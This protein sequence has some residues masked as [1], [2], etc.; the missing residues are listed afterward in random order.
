M[1]SQNISLPS[2]NQRIRNVIDS[3][4]KGSVRAFCLALGFADSQKI[5]RLF[6]LDKRNNRYPKPSIDVL[7]LISNKLDISLLWLQTGEGQMLKDGSAEK[8]Q[9]QNQKADFRLVP[10]YNLDARG[11]F[12]DNDEVDVP[13]Y[14]VDHIPFKDAEENDICMPISGNSMAPTYCAGAIVLLHRVER[15]AEFLELGQVYMIVLKDGRRLIKELRAS[16]EDRKTK[17][18]CV[19]HNPAY[20]PVE[21]PKDMISL[22]FLVRAVYAKTAM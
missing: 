3:D 5:N 4:Y 16:Q 14:V 21:L 20:D 18:L 12:A 19:S 8:Q 22:V 13:E 10:M 17:Y 7:E 9:Q 6:N 11:G 15:W 2:V 1:K